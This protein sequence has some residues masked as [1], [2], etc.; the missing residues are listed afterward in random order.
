M[1][2]NADGA[3]RRHLS[4]QAAPEPKKPG[5]RIPEAAS[6]SGEL[7]EG[8]RVS[9]AFRSLGHF[10]AIVGRMVTT[11]T[12][13]YPP[14]LRRLAFVPAPWRFPARI[15]SGSEASVASARTM[16]RTPLTIDMPTLCHARASVIRPVGG[17][18]HRY[19]HRA[20]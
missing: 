3:Q 1:A 15:M 20:A 4:G 10:T 7:G 19:E 2:T 14:S 6:D 12:R 5:P 13:E 9:G 11:S 18:H 8:D 17:L 16:Y